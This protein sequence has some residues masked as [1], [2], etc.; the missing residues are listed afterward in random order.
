[1]AI[2]KKESHLPV[3]VDPSQGCGRSD[4]V[5]ELCKGAVA[6]GADGLLVEVHPNP[7]EALSDGQQQVD[8]DS[9]RTLVDGVQPF[10]T[11]TG[12]TL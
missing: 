2:A 7:A 10:L 1:M 12:R 5:T 11:A 6:L 8:F 4:L 9:F 3:V